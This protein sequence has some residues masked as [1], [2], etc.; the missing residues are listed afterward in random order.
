MERAC[1]P[2]PSHC[3]K[4]MKG[5]HDAMD[6]LNGKWTIF[7]IGALNFG[8]RRFAD[9]LTIVE[10][11]GPKML[12]KGLQELELNG[13]VKRSVVETDR[14]NISYETTEYGKTLFPIIRELSS[15]GTGHRKRVMGKQ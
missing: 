9:L 6:V 3:M 2:A 11:I 1:I 15:W 12:T 4:H 8:P 13:I 7:I 5:I 14:V 10:G